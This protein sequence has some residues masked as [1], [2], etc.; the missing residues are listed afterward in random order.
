MSANGNVAPIVKWDATLQPLI[1]HLHHFGAAIQVLIPLDQQSKLGPHTRDGVYLGPAQ[2][3]ATHHHILVQGH[4]IKMRNVMFSDHNNSQRPPEMLLQ[5][6][7]EQQDDSDT[8]TMADNP[9]HHLPGSTRCALQD[10]ATTTPATC[11]PSTTMLQ[12]AEATMMAPP[13]PTDG[14]KDHITTNK[15]AHP[16]PVNTEMQPEQTITAPALNTKPANNKDNEPAPQPPTKRPRPWPL[17]KK[18]PAQTHQPNKNIYNHDYQ[19]FTAADLK[20]MPISMPNLY[21]EAMASP[22]A[23]LWLEAMTKEIN[24][25]TRNGMFWLVCLKAGQQLVHVGY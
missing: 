4:I 20:S 7:G 11:T 24:A 23:H 12:A 1:M 22:E 16:S 25:I 2:E 3:N 17:P 9:I 10:N 14:C 13:L 15:P 8:P 19:V 18:P 6:A 5:L 21:C